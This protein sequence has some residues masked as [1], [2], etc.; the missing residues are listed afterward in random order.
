MPYKNEVANKTSHFDIVKNPEVA[1]FIKSC[2]Y[3]KVPSESE[4]KKMCENF[5]DIENVKSDKLPDNIISI[6]GSFYEA[7]ISDELPSTKIGYVKIGNMLI[8]RKEYNK[9]GKN[10]FVDPFEVSKFQNNNLSMTFTFPSSNI[11]TKGTDSLKDSFRKELD[12]QLLKKRTKENDYKTSLRTTLFHLAALRP[13]GRGTRNTNK[14]QIYRCPNEECEGRNIELLDI[15]EQQYCPHCHK[16]I[17]PSD[18]LRLWEEVYEYQSN[19]SVLSRFMLI[20]EHMMPIHYIRVMKE[21]NKESYANILSKL[22]FIIDGPLAIFGTAAWL[23][24]CIMKYVYNINKELKDMGFDEILYLG[25]QK[26]GQIAEYIKLIDKYLDKNRIFLIDDDYRYKY[27]SPN[28]NLASK[29]FGR[30]TYYGQD[31]IYKNDLGKILSFAVIFPFYN[32]EGEFERQKLEISNYTKINEVINLL[33]EF[34]CNL[35]ENSIIPVA[36]AHKYT[37]IS[38]EPGGRVL[39]LLSKH[40]IEK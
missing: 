16:P 40:Y 12:K 19:T 18:C 8:K 23:H 24:A 3:I 34:K 36:L 37:A 38:F 14:I 27:I 28:K 10:K 4:G 2:D 7:S 31:F 9:L 32:K 21:T 22:S 33:N 39:D 20:M 13:D 15:E 25:V 29:G 11:V 35:Y 30:E 26:T 6:D 5:K 1:E 17:Y